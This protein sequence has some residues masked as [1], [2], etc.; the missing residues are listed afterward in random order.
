MVYSK[1]RHDISETD[2]DARCSRARLL[3]QLGRN[4]KCRGGG[5]GGDGRR[6]GE[7]DKPGG[8]RDIAS[9]EGGREESDGEID[10]EEEEAEDSKSKSTKSEKLKSL[11]ASKVEEKIAEKHALE[12]RIKELSLEIK[13]S[14]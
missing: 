4:D 13:A 8:E 2:S 3:A 7:G 6:Q 1:A 11:K 14:E 9:E 12:D 10:I 5:K